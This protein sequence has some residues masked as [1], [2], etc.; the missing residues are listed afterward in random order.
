MIELERLLKMKSINTILNKAANKI[1]KKF[2]NELD[3]IILYGSYMKGKE[4][5]N[6]IDILL[7]FKNRVNKK[8][9]SEF[10]DE[11]IISEFN[12]FDINSITINELKGDGFIAKEGLYLEGKSLLSGKLLSE[13]LGFISLAFVKYDISK[14]KGSLRTR[15]YYSLIGRGVSKGFLSEIKGVRY[16]NNVIICEYSVIE[17]LK[18]FLNHWNIEYEITPSLV[19]KRLKNIILKS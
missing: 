19:P 11:L 9:E 3:D 8:I 4:K 16:S 6:D 17:K 15:L 12:K 7:I 13:S 2:E 18:E 1:L 14:I 10:K 5:Y